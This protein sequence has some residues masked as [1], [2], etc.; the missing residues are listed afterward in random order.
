MNHRWPHAQWNALDNAIAD[1]LIL[2]GSEVGPSGANWQDVAGT[3]AV[4]L[5]AVADY[6]DRARNGHIRD[7]NIPSLS[8]ILDGHDI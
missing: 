8:D 2:E 3:A 4:N 7:L 6:L 1:L 5:R